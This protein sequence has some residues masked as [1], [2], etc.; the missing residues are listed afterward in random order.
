MKKILAVLT[1]LIVVFNCSCV[2][3]ATES[4]NPISAQMDYCYYEGSTIYSKLVF[5][6]NSS[7]SIMYV[8][9]YHADGYL[10][11]IKKYSVSAGMMSLEF[12]IGDYVSENADVLK[13]FFL[14]AEDGITPLGSSVEFNL[15]KTILE[16]YVT[17]TY[18]LG[19]KSNY[20]SVNFEYYDC[21]G[22]PYF[23]EMLID[24]Y[25]WT[26]TV[27]LESDFTNINDYYGVNARVEVTKSDNDTYKIQKI[28]PVDAD[29]IFELELS[30]IDY[31]SETR[32]DYYTDSS[33][34]DTAAISLSQ[35][36]EFY[37]N[38]QQED[39]ISCLESMLGMP[40]EVS[41]RLIENTGDAKYDIV[42]IR[43][44]T[45]D[46]V[47]SI[48]TEKNRIEG[49][50]YSCVLD[51]SVPMTMCNSA[52]ERMD[53]ADFKED[54]IFAFISSNGRT[55]NYDWI[56]IINYANNYVTGMVE[57]CTPD[58]VFINDVEYGLAC[59]G[60]NLGDQGTFYLTKTGKVFDCT[61]PMPNY[62]YIIDTQL[63]SVGWDEAWQIKMLCN[64]GKTRIYTVRDGF[65]LDGTYL[66]ANDT[67]EDAQL[68]LDFRASSDGNWNADPEKRVVE[69]YL[70]YKGLIR[71]I[72][73]TACREFTSE[74]YDK[75]T[76]SIDG[77]EINKNAVIF[78]VSAPS[79]NDAYATDINC[80]IDGTRYSGYLIM[81]YDGEID[82]V[83]IT[84]GECNYTKPEETHS[85]SDALYGYAYG[86]YY[87]SVSGFESAWHVELLGTNNEIITMPCSDNLRINGE[88][89]C[90]SSAFRE[91]LGDN[92]A[93]V[94]YVIM[95]GEYISEIN[96]PTT[97]AFE[98]ALYSAQRLGETIVTDTTVVF[99]MS[100]EM[101]GTKAL[102][103]G[104][105]YC[106][107]GITDESGAY[108]HIVITDGG[109]RLPEIIADTQY[110][111]MLASTMDTN[112]WE[113]SWQISLLTSS[114]SK[115]YDVSKRFS[116]DGTAYSNTQ[117][118]IEALK[119]IEATADSDGNFDCAITDNMA[120]R[121]AEVSFDINGDIKAIKTLSATRFE[122]Q[123]YSAASQ[124]LSVPIA[125]DP[126][127]F[128]ISSNRIDTVKAAGIDYLTNEC[129]Y[130]GSIVQNADGKYDLVIITERGINIDT[131]QSLAIVANVTHV[132]LNDMDAL[133]VRYYT[134]N[135]DEL[136]EA[137]IFEDSEACEFIG[138]CEY[139]DIQAGSVLMLKE[140]SDGMALAVAV[141]ANTFGDYGITEDGDWYQKVTVNDTVTD[142]I[143]L[144]ND[145]NEFVCGYIADFSNS[146]SGKVII[147]MDGERII[148]TRNTNAYT[149]AD[150]AMNR[151]RIYSADWRALDTIDRYDDATEMGTFFIAR[152]YQGSC[153]DIITF[154][155]RRPVDV[156]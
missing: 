21:S 43:E 67:S 58:S 15:G 87:D 98:N 91:V 148:V 96:T 60:I 2:C 122:N 72:Y 11:Q 48:D 18:L 34:Y 59:G 155:T 33:K 61:H 137:I 73:S 53:I 139:Y 17:G 1:A 66:S 69:Y 29:S 75:E 13:V 132:T 121:I 125:D 31:C 120:N 153:K 70:N 46:H 138:D 3:M 92:G 156:Q 114:G 27:T 63:Y 52:G 90:S 105:S 113:S 38:Y 142:A 65:I 108:S 109:T 54:D 150:S 97:S 80:L 131:T 19:D 44:Y 104:E 28:T 144:A 95:D 152:K 23:E 76:L 130:S 10:K 41:V 37:L 36:A 8:G 47:A 56:E 42:D 55:H 5:D 22:N 93:L 83:V 117:T 25:D 4:G 24:S 84:A 81:N 88:L 112:G 145:N 103:D 151:L 101:A 85:Y 118:D 39:D 127:V 140:G 124:S 143:E 57:E 86:A 94:S 102:K 30:D 74:F 129:K 147:A 20:G 82:G 141:I 123:K 78:N 64:D 51:E 111:Y 6:K 77:Y 116:I 32:I 89:E 49:Y 146:T 100:S 149:I 99:D 119:V 45:Y 26:A 134:D 115:I 126:I 68:L 79:A 107:Y 9:V 133:K 14:D 110:A 106:G 62:G 135:S 12:Q 154:G 40:A 136:K 71:E 50:L 7:D 16:G 35:S 128:D